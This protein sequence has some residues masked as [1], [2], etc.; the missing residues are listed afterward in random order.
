MA[1][2]QNLFHAERTPFPAE[3]GPLARA[4]LRQAPPPRPGYPIGAALPAHAALQDAHSVAVASRSRR[5]SSPELPQWLMAPV[6]RS[7][8]R[9]QEG[10]P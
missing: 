3:Q 2:S 9:T 8:E 6:D 7:A 10:M 4:L 5:W 1:E